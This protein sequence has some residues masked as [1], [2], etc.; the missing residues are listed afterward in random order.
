MKEQFLEA[1][2]NSVLKVGKGIEAG[3][4][5][6]IR[7]TPETIRQFLMSGVIMEAFTIFGELIF[8][9]VFLVTWLVLLKWF[10]KLHIEESLGSSE[11]KNVTPEEKAK[12]RKF[13][14]INGATTFGTIY[15]YL[16]LLL[17]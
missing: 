14:K 5:F 11:F 9:S 10:K 17:V 2:F 8:M 16:V 6:A 4:D 3:V 15:I 1:I 13:I 12:Q 7:E